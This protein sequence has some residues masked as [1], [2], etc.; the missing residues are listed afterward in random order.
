MH[1]WKKRLQ[2]AAALF[3]TLAL[4]A[5]MVPSAA[6]AQ[7]PSTAAQVSLTQQSNTQG[8]PEGETTPPESTPARFCQV[9]AGKPM[10]DSILRIWVSIL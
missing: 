7:E 8:A 2:R 4:C 3:C 9:S 5:G 1:F 10:P 6:F